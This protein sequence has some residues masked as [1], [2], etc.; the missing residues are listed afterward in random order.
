[1]ADLRRCRP[2]PSP[3]ADHACRISTREAVHQ[4]GAAQGD[5]ADAQRLPLLPLHPA[6]RSGGLRPA[7]LLRRPGRGLSH[8]ACRACPGGMHLRA[9][10]RSAGRHAVRSAGAR[11]GQGRGRR[12]RQASGPLCRRDAPHPRGSPVRLD[13]RHASLP[14]QLPQPL[15]GLGRLRA[16]GGTAVQRLSGRRLF[17]GV[18]QPARRRF[19]ALAPCPEGSPRRAGPGVDQDAGPGKPGRPA[20]AHRRGRALRRPRSPV[21]LLAMRLR[22]RRRRQLDRRGHAMGQARPDRRYGPCRW[23]RPAVATSLGR[24]QRASS[25]IIDRA[26]GVR[27]QRSSA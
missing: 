2:D 20:S 1:M 22:Q 11:A 19:L 12:S 5:P 7:A 27:P 26:T 18:R 21:A 8:G 14:R 16:G 13:G 24:H 4:D 25:R 6:L 10:G 17:P 3:R 23:G 9:D 15:D